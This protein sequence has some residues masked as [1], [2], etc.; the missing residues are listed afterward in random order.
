[1]TSLPPNLLGGPL[2]LILRCLTTVKLAAE[3]SKS[4]FSAVPLAW[5][6]PGD[7]R[8]VGYSLD[9]LDSDSKLTRLELNE[10]VPDSIEGLLQKMVS[11]APAGWDAE[12][13]DLLQRSCVRG[14]GPAAASKAFLARI[15]NECGLLVLD[16]QDPGLQTF[17]SEALARAANQSARTSALFQD[18]AS[19]LR[20]AGYGAAPCAA[21][22]KKEEDFIQAWLVLNSILPATVMVAGSSDLG[23]LSLALPIF[24]ELGQAPPLV[25]PRLSATLVDARTRKIQDKYKLGIEDFFAGTGEVLRKIGLQEAERIGIVRFEG[26]VAEI[27]TAIRELAAS[28]YEDG[29]QQEVTSSREKMLYQLVKLRERFLSA[30]KV[31]REAALRHLERACNTVAPHGRPQECELAALYFLLRYSRAILP[32]IYDKM[33]V[34]SHDHQLIDLD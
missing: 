25:W 30:C 24:R 4:G 2:C 8:H 1:M 7:G 33:N 27:E 11:I 9:F 19:K 6:Q 3:L 13:M 15:M 22:Q 10:S 12:M 29:L 32:R 18:Y 28:A 26:L 21:W 20:Q 14:V 31:R 34:W 23:A 17:A 16:P 5:I